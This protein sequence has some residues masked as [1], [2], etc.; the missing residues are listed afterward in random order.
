M[1]LN[2]KEELR[3]IIEN[4]FPCYRQFGFSWK[5]AMP[6]KISKETALELLPKYSPGMGYWELSERVIYGYPS[7]VF[8]EYSAS[9]M[10]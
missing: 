1:D 9:D 3:K 8:T 4:G 10:V 2:N 7:L 5:G 6:Y